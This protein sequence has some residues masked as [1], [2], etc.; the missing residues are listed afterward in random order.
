MGGLEGM[1]VA[2]GVEQGKEGAQTQPSLA[3]MD[4]K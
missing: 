2:A 1:P 4:L 3:D